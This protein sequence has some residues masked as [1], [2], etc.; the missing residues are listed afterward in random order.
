MKVLMTPN[1][2]PRRGLPVKIGNVYANAHG[3][4]HYKVVVGIIPIDK[5]QRPYNRVVSLHIDATGA[6]VGCSRNPE[7]YIRDHNDLVGKVESM[8]ELKIKW[9]HSH[10]QQEKL[11]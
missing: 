2:A 7:E 3:A 1:I 6:I 5:W 11:K 10:P 9:I 8:P 4:P